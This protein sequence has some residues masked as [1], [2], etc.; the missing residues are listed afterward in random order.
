VKIGFVQF[1]P[2]L[3]DVPATIRKLDRLI[4]RG[5]AADVWV[6]PELCNSGYN[7][8]S[9]ERAWETSDE[10]T[11]SAF[12]QYLEAVCARHD[13]HIVS[14][15]N[16][17]DGDSLYNS[18][19]LVGPGGYIGTYRKLHLFMK[20]KDYFAPGDV[21]LPVFDIG[22]CKLGMLVCFDWIFPEVWRI[23]ALKG[24]DLICHPANLVLP[25]LAQR[26]IPVHALMNRVYIVTANRIGVEDD[27]AFTGLSTIAGPTGDVLI[28]ASQLE[29]EMGVADV[30]VGL[31]RDKMITSRNHIF[32]DRRPKDYSFLLGGEVQL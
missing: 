26:A 7:F 30:D 29:E 25:G 13:C 24:V 10:I 28:Q 14:G 32:T 27:L 8:G 12:I 23:L 4:G 21:G 9:R 31:A 20:E 15:F 18:A 2:A 19:I 5:A 6:L 11:G 3:G 17:R 1:A 22:S 16:E